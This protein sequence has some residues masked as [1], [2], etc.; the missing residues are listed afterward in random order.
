VTTG[1]AESR[2]ASCC[3]ATDADDDDDDGSL[4]DKKH[5]ALQQ[6]CMLHPIAFYAEIEMMGDILSLHHIMLWTT[7]NQMPSNSS[8][9]SSKTSIS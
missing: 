3:G 4:H 9:S 7:T 2:E 5:L 1:R 8:S 6:D